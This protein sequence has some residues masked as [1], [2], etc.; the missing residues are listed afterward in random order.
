MRTTHDFSASWLLKSIR[1]VALVAIVGLGLSACSEAESRNAPEGESA[2]EQAPE[3]T[4]VAAGTS[5]TFTVDRTVSTDTDEKG[6]YF[7]ATLQSPVIGSDGSPIIPAGAV[8]RWMVT[9]SSTQDG[10]SVLGVRL[11]SIRVDG[12]P[13]SVEST[14]TDATIDTDN[15]DSDGETA[16]KIGVGA[17]AGALIGQIIGRD[18]ES[19]L[20]GAGVGA[21]VGTAVALSTRGGSATL[22]AGS[23]LVVQLDEPLTL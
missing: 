1:P 22:P 4:T 19:T 18:T 23:R 9:E 5:M 13:V 17:A 21:A 10:R 2:V 14:V 16:A 15:P 11:E 6:A 12:E 3:V 7:T 20:A 8:S